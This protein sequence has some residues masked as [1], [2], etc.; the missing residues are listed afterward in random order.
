[1]W[2]KKK[3]KV[4]KKEKGTGN[5]LPICD[6]EGKEKTK[7]ENSEREREWEREREHCT[8]GSHRSLAKITDWLH[9]PM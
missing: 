3:K 4:W 6:K 8:E 9:I 1:M 5:Q 7:A 2:K